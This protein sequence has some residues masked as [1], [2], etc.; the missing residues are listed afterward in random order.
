MKHTSHATATSPTR[1][2]KRIKARPHQVSSQCGGSAITPPSPS[3]RRSQLSC[4]MAYIRVL[5]EPRMTVTVWCAHNRVAVLV[6]VGPLSI[7]SVMP[8]GV[9]CAVGVR[10]MN[11]ANLIALLS[12]L[13]ALTAC[14]LMLQRAS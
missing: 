1:A 9:V 11:R 6:L 8:Y 7:R 10:Q 14:V 12:A 3:S 4:L 5:A 13:V 2:H